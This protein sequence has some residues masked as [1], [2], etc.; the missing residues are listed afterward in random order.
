MNDGEPFQV[1]GVIRFRMP[2]PEVDL[3]LWDD[4]GLLPEEPELLE[5][6]LGVTADLVEELTSWG[7][8]WNARHRVSDSEAQEERLRDQAASLVEKVR[9]QLRDGLQIEMHLR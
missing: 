2:E 9:R 7:A 6:G 1:E 8:A 5:A 3:P 4:G